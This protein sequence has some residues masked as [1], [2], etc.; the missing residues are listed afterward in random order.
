MWQLR[1]DNGITSAG[2]VIDSST[3]R[4]VDASP[5]GEWRRILDRYPSLAQQF[6]DSRQIAPADG[7]HATRRMQRLASQ[8]A[9]GNWALLPNAAGFVD[10]LHSTGIAHTLCGIERLTR[11]FAEHW[12]KPTMAE[13]LTSYSR[14][15]RQECELIDLLVHGCYATRKNFRAFTAF[16]MLYFAAATTYERRRLDDGV[17]DGFLCADD[18]QFV[19][20]VKSLWTQLPIQSEYK[21]TAVDQFE[22]SVAWRLRP[23]NYA[24]LCDP[25]VRNMYARTALPT[26]TE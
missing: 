15:V 4:G 3:D 23:Y 26:G 22:Q 13:Q 14:L 19:A 5:L 9:G 1:F 25:A 21:S 7:L 10:P 17:R 18:P 20:I 12:R 16:S 24:G 8:V 2:F 6:A 11:I